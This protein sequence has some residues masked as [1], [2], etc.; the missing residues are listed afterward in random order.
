MLM[1]LRG[2]KLFKT[3]LFYFIAALILYYFTHVDDYQQT[4]EINEQG[5]RPSRRR[6]GLDQRAV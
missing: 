3:I 2:C 5:E 4:A 1:M 6:H